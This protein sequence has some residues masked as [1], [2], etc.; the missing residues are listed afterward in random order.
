MKKYLFIL[1]SLT[2]LTLSCNHKNKQVEIKKVSWENR[3]AHLSST[4]N[5][6]SGKIYLPVY[7]HIY[8]RFDHHI[9]NLTITVSIRNMSDKESIYLTSVDY[10][11]T[12]GQKIRQYIDHM[13]YIKPMETIEI[14][15]AEED[16]EG[17][18]G[19]NFIFDWMSSNPQNKP[20]IEAVMIS[21]YGQQGLSFSTRGVEVNE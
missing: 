11:N 8:H 10:Y 16:Q 18:S 2:F 3:K 6:Y 9:F 7:S 13:V 15:I 17:G 5:L 21:T 19:A 20:L 14:I 12:Q 1:I 4:E